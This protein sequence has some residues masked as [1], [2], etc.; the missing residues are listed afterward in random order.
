MPKYGQ[1]CMSSEVPI[2]FRPHVQDLHNAICC[3]SSPLMASIMK[4]LNLDDPF[5]SQKASQAPTRR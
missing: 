5:T 2:R 3:S 4:T 1:L